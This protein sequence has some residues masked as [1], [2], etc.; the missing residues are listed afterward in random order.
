MNYNRRAN[1]PDGN[2]YRE[3]RR[4]TLGGS[5]GGSY[6]GRSLFTW[7]IIVAGILACGIAATRW[8]FW[9]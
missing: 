3:M 8:I 9:K 2:V 1:R 4:R 7:A 5:R 6:R